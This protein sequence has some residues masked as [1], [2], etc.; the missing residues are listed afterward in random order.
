[1]N[2]A[3][4]A[5]DPPDAPNA[6]NA[7][8]GSV[9]HPRL[10]RR[11]SLLY[12][13]GVAFARRTEL[14]ELI[15]LVMTQCCSALGAESASVLLHDVER[16]ELYFPYVAEDDPAAAAELLQLRFPADRGIAG[17]VLQSGRS[18]RSDDL[19]NDPRFYGGVDR[20]TG[21]TTRAMISVPLH[22]RHETIGVIQVRNPTDGGV[23]DDHDL[24]FMEALSG[25]VSVAIENARM[26]AQLRSQVA[27]LEQAVRTK[28]ELLGIRKE[29][30]IARNIQQS[31]LPRVFPA[32]PERTEFEL[33]A[34]MI[35]AQE[36]GGD[37]YD[38]FMIDEHRIGLVIADVSGKGVPAA[39]FMAVT[40]TLLRST[41]LA[42]LSPA[43]CLTRVNALVVPE[44]ASRMFITVFYGILDLRT[45]ALSFSNG[46]HDAP[47]V[48]R[49]A[50]HAE[51]LSRTGD[52]VL[53]ALDSTVYRE[54]N[55]ILAAGDV[56]LLYTDGVTE[57]M[58]PAGAEFSDPRL[59]AFLDTATS[60]EPEALIAS[61]IDAVRDYSRDAAQSDDITLLAIRYR[62]T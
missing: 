21:K 20:R 6:L 30:D 38:F 31:I 48:V 44:N 11:A 55:A 9:A 41:A 37:F 61:L 33:F 3:L 1:V 10:D 17:A 46:G 18:I 58:D 8:N 56:L 2:S 42:G 19:A 34:E 43:A 7:P 13:L 53:G 60:A 35:P 52:M 12:E 23:F 59:A 26:Y 49:A 14:E 39:L 40:R 51:R 50:G 32:F 57:A 16:N 22:G 62:G 15:P 27:A 24:A 5:P 29:L 45:G 28:N 54:G 4:N 47:Y 36:V 25:S